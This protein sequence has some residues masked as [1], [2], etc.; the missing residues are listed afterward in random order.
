MK[1]NSLFQSLV[2]SPSRFYRDEI[3]IIACAMIGPHALP[4]SYRG[5][6]NNSLFQSLVNS[7]SR[8]YRDEISIIAC[9]MIGPHALPLSYRGITS[10][11]KL[12]NTD[13]LYL[14][15]SPFF[16]ESQY[17]RLKFRALTFLPFRGILTQKII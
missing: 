7:P 15:I 16:S 5:M 14:N 11:K 10:F 2:N 17:R 6:K 13:E 1:N 4:L 9:A 12:I 3:S 8:F